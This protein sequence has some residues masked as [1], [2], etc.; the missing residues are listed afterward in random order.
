MPF[1]SGRLFRDAFGREII[2][3]PK[4]PK[5]VGRKIAPGMLEIRVNTPSKLEKAYAPPF[6]LS[7]F[8][9]YNRKT[10]WID[11]HQSKLLKVNPD[12]A[13]PE[14]FHQVAI[15]SGE[16]TSGSLHSDSLM[17]CQTLLSACIPMMYGFEHLKPT[18]AK[19]PFHQ[20]M[21][22]SHDF[23][24]DATRYFSVRLNSGRIEDDLIQ[25]GSAY[26]RFKHSEDF[27]GVGL[28]ISQMAMVC[29]HDFIRDGA[30]HINSDISKHTSLDIE[31]NTQLKRY[32]VFGVDGS[33]RV[34]FR[35]NI[36]EFFH[37]RNMFK[38]AIPFLTGFSF[39]LE[40]T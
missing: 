15:F 26:M 22:V 2:F 39:V 9:A 7:Q 13:N 3:N 32:F 19:L 35:L 27:I 10:L 12:E 18:N 5:I 20:L 11:A 29:V 28:S 31:Y 24:S 1:W 40:A 14:L 34:G 33:K 21:H 25:F 37:L 36:H 17:E 8:L 23:R 4:P 16:F 30:L 38:F 6:A